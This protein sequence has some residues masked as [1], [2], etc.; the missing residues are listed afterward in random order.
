MTNE[1]ATVH[2]Q[3]KLSEARR[4]RMARDD[5]RYQT[6]IEGLSAA[7][8]ER[9][10]ARS[11]YWATKSLLEFDRASIAHLNALSRLELP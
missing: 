5:P 2:A 4:D 7:V 10:L 8:E 11:E 9:E 3:A 6:R 1:P